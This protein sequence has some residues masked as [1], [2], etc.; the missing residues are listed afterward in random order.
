MDKH[1]DAGFIEESHCNECVGRHLV[2]AFVPSIAEHSNAKDVQD[3]QN[4]SV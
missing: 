4:L 2:S 3:S 1:N